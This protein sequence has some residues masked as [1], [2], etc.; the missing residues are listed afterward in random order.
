M[1]VWG[2]MLEGLE[3]NR[4][5]FVRLPAPHHAPAYLVL[6]RGNQRNVDAHVEKAM[7]G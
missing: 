2:R 3:R 6:R 5:L 1:R 7:E 4:S